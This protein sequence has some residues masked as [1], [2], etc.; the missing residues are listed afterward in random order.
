MLVMAAAFGSLT[1]VA[2]SAHADE[3]AYLVNVTV[4]PGYNFADANAAMPMA[5]G[6]QNSR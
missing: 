1:V 2:G 4:R 3:V 5:A 6:R